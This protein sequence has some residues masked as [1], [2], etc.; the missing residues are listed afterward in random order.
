MLIGTRRWL[1]RWTGWSGKRGCWSS[2]GASSAPRSSCPAGTGPCRWCRMSR[3]TLPPGPCHS[4]SWPGS[5]RFRSTLSCCRKRGR[6]YP[7]SPGRC[8]NSSGIPPHCGCSPGWR[9]GW[10]PPPS[11]R[12]RPIGSV[13]L[14]C[15]QDILCDNR[16]RGA[17]VA[18]DE[19][20]HRG[21]DLLRGHR[22]VSAHQTDG[23]EGPERHDARLLAEPIAPLPDERRRLQ[24]EAGGEPEL[25]HRLLQLALHAGV[26]ELRFRG[27][28]DGGNEGVGLDAV[29]AR[30]LSGLILIG[31][32]DLPLR[33]LAA[34]RLDG[35]AQ[36]G[37]QSVA[38]E[39]VLP[40]LRM[41][42]IDDVDRQLR[43]FDGQWP[44]D[45]HGDALEG[46]VL[47]ELL[48]EVHPDRAG[49]A[50]DKGFHGAHASLTAVPEAVTINIPLFS[51][52]TS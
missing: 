9:R 52:R 34:R 18:L 11:G 27:R 1:P 42:E 47:Q 33:L 40:L 19:A 39:Q 29:C 44:P 30:G 23:V 43:V 28:A 15:F 8:W 51:P 35:R 36:A 45:E 21:G 6:S 49:R 25:L 32:I 12:Y 5:D 24:D 22:L 14:S 48:D 46:I 20:D 31:I 2:S 17:A 16:F 50:D 37:E 26:E 13:L 7:S 41:V 4:A 3:C 10:P 38:L